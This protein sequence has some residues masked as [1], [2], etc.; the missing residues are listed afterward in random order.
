MTR[1]SLLPPICAADND[2]LNRLAD[3][4]HIAGRDYEWRRWWAPDAAETKAAKR[5]ADAAAERFASATAWLE[6]HVSLADW[7]P[8]SVPYGYRKP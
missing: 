1:S 2:T 4:A 6:N 8:S 3:H 7:H 5:T